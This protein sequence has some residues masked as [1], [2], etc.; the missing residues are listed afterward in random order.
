[1]RCCNVRSRS[2]HLNMKTFRPFECCMVPCWCRAGGNSTLTQGFVTNRR[3]QNL[4]EFYTRIEWWHPA[5]QPASQ[6]IPTLNLVIAILA[7]LA[8]PSRHILWCNLSLSLSP[9]QLGN[10]QD[11]R[12]RSRMANMYLILNWGDVNLT[13][14]S[15]GQQSQHQ[16]YK[17]SP[18]H[19][20][21]LG[22]APLLIQSESCLT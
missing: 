13:C 19:T 22:R 15:G 1:M 21:H 16:L 8:S 18:A 7:A 17:H 11:Q 14:S 9:S 3:E 10:Y 5:S 4:G 6:P 12:R 2:V 20:P